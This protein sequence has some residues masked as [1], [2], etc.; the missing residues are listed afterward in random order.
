M[1]IEAEIKKLYNC[2]LLRTQAECE[3]FDHILEKLA[4][5]TEEKMIRDLCMVFD[6]ETHQEEV[7]FGL[8][9][10]IESFEMDKYLTEMAKALPDMVYKAREWARILNI[11][12]LNS[13]TYRN[14]Y[15]KVL[16]HMDSKVKTIVVDL[17]IDI[18]NDDPKR[19]AHTADEL[20]G[21]L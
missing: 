9:H 21:I 6:D 17:L 1:N 20:I 18:K 2:R 7:M 13:E 15:V 11:R 14:E 4:D 12:I 10:F 16:M 8:I 5:Y 19:F 3:E